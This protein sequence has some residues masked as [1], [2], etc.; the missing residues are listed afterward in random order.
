MIRAIR[1][2]EDAVRSLG[3][4]VF[5]HKLQSLMIGGAFGGLS[6]IMLGI[7]QQNVDA[8]F[9]IPL[10]TFY[11]Y[12]IVVLGGPG[13]IWGPI[14]GAVIF[15]FLFEFFEEFFFDVVE[16]GMARW[17]D[18]HH[19]RWSDPLRAVRSRPN[20]AHGVSAPGVFGRREEMLIDD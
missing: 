9:Y 4:N 3:K 14:A 17:R 10:L 2:D 7:E 11:A 13:T 16:A 20:G 15:W 6:G 8:D 12:T 18:R 5:W 19:R 1:E